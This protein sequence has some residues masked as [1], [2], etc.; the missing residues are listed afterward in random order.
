[1]G[2]RVFGWLSLGSLAFGAAFGSR[3]GF[4]SLEVSFGAARDD[5]FAVAA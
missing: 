2:S 5:S 3:A 4:A 1:L